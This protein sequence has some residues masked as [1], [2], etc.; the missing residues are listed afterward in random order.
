M[1][2]DWL[3]GDLNGRLEEVGEKDFEGEKDWAEMKRQRESASWTLNKE[4]HLTEADG[5]DR[6][7]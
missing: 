6:V 2:D 1:D 4:R 3:S 5:D 7:S